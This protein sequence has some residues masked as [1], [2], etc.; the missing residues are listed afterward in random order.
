MTGSAPDVNEHPWPRKSPVRLNTL[1]ALLAFMTIMASLIVAYGVFSDQLWRSITGVQQERV[2]NVATTLS[3]S[4]EVIE[5]LTSGAPP[6]PDSDIEQ[7]MEA[8]REL[9][10]VNFIVIVDPDSIRLTHPNREWIGH[11]F[12]GG[13]EGPAL[14]GARY[15][16]LAIGTLGTSIRGFAPVH[17][18]SGHIIGA[19]S[20]GVTLSHL[21]PLR[22]ASHKRLLFLFLAI[23]AIGGLGSAWL[24]RTIRRR[25]MGMEPDDIARLVAER[26]VTLDAIHEGVI[27]VDAQANVTLINPAARSLLG[28]LKAHQIVLGERLRVLLPGSERGHHALSDRAVINRRMQLG[29]RAFLGNYQPML[30]DGQLVGAVMT[31]RDSHEMQALAE[32]LTGVRRYAEA[33]RATTHEFKNK[34][35]VILGLTQLEDLPALRQYLRELVDYRHAVSES[36][37]ERVREPVLAGF[38]I[39]KQ[40]EAREKGITLS[41]EAD[42]PIP[43]ASDGA[44]VHALVS[45]IGNLLENAFEALDARDDPRVAIHMA[46]ES[47]MLSLQIQDNGAGIDPERQTHIFERGISSKGERRGLGLFLVR[48]QVDAVEGTLSLYSLPGQGTLIEVSYP[49]RPANGASHDEAASGRT[50]Q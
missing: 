32:E 49:Y 31:F 4:S 29:G 40:S 36:I 13:D 33:L 26:R 21:A 50:R 17:D 11:R 25:L 8:L 37:V 2:V 46:L 34:L 35:H 45:I 30:A 48:E 24:A 1:A 3:R 23:L 16:S 9:L 47:R 5:A 18:A 22:A 19:V 15:A 39:G 27:A 14:E 20:V 38:L 10:N 12:R 6:S 42:T 41:V 43:Q 44:T 28:D 7:R